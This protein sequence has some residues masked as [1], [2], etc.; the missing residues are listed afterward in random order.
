MKQKK[1]YI[2]LLFLTIAPMLF[3]MS[4]QLP[5]GPPPPTPPPGLPVDG[6]LISL[7]VAGVF[8]GI[9]KNINKK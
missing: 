7:V 2:L 6:G 4:S 8:Y 9:K 3:A 1:A 5:E